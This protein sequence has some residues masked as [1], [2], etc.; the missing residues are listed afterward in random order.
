MQKRICVPLIEKKK[1]KHFFF[2][3]H[4]YLNLVGESSHWEMGLVLATGINIIPGGGK[5]SEEVFGS[6]PCFT[7][8]V[9]LCPCYSSL[10]NEHLYH[11]VE[12]SYYVLHIHGSNLFLGW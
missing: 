4:F 5:I 9:D 3:F 1:W 12:N 6:C 2:I 8:W 7:C 11:Q 10:G